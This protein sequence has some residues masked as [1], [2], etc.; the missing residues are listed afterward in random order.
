EAEARRH[1]LLRAENLLRLWLRQFHHLPVL[2]GCGIAAAAGPNPTRLGFFSDRAVQTRGLLS[3]AGPL[4]LSDQSRRRCCRR[5]L[6]AA[7]VRLRCRS[8]LQRSLQRLEA[9]HR[10]RDRRRPGLDRSAAHL[11]LQSRG[12]EEAWSRGAS[13]ARL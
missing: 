8:A 12:P 13:R 11:S 6:V 3:A 5:F 4:Y 9:T 1:L 2:G 10:S 7:H